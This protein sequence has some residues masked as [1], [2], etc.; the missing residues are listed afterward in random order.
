[1]PLV[2]FVGVGDAIQECFPDLASPIL[3]ELLE[4]P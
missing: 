2:F 1:M 4:V 3:N